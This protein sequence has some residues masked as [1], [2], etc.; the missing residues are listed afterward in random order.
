LIVP[1]FVLCAIGFADT[2]GTSWQWP[3]LALGLANLALFG[4]LLVN[5]R[6]RD[7][8]PSSG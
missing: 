7:R 1:S 5:W 4:W 8:H 6:H 3:W 2:S